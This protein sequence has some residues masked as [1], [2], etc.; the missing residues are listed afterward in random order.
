MGGGEKVGGAQSCTVVEARAQAVG[1]HQQEA[2]QEG[3]SVEELRQRHL[4]LPGDATELR[5]HGA[6]P[7]RG[8]DTR[9]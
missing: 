2:L 4:L 7:W 9:L 6:Q 1:L 5:E 3:N 8:A